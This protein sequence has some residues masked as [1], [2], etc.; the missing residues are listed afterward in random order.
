MEKKYINWWWD[1]GNNLGEQGCES[2]RGK[3]MK[4]SI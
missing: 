1:N 2:K 4:Y 3:L